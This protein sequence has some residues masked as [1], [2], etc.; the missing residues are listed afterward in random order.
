MA[1]V[2]CTKGATVVYFKGLPHIV[3]CTVGLAVLEV[4]LF[5]VT[6]VGPTRRAGAAVLVPLKVRR[7]E[8]Q[9]T[10]GADKRH[11]AAMTGA[12]ITACNHW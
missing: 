3:I 9:L 12:L 6:K 4:A 2:V 10:T 8:H 7:H 5:A 11:L 1:T